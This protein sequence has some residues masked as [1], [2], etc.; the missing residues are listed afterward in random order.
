[1]S[2]LENQTYR[3]KIEF[4][5]T[6]NNDH[7]VVITLSVSCNHDIPKDILSNIESNIN[8]LFFKDYESMETVKVKQDI[9]KEIEKE[10]KELAKLQAKNQ[11]K[12]QEQQ[13]ISNKKAELEYQK[14]LKMK[15]V[16]GKSGF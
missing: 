11:K 7:K 15:P 10:K 12:Q 8:E 4:C 6:D 14:Q 16:Y 5:K 13:M 3:K 9:E 1:M 2:L